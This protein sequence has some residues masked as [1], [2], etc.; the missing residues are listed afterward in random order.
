MYHVCIFCIGADSACGLVGHTPEV[1]VLFVGSVVE[2]EESEMVGRVLGV[3]HPTPERREREKT[4]ARGETRDK[5]ET[6]HRRQ[7]R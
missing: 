2:K 7:R 3:A 6:R 5:R 4:E 1:V